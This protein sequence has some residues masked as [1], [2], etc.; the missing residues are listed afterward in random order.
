MPASSAPSSPGVVM[1]ETKILEGILQKLMY[2]DTFGSPKVYE[3]GDDIQTHL[4]K[5]DDYIN[6][7]GIQGDE[8]KIAVLCN[9]ICDEARWELCGLLEFD[10]NKNDYSWIKSR[11]KKLF[12][13]KATKITPL[14]KLFQC[15]QKT[16]QRTREFLSEI[17]RQGYLLMKG[18]DSTEREAHMTKAFINGLGNKNVK[19]ALAQMTVTTLDEAYELV[20]KEYT[21][22]SNDTE[23]DDVAR[24]R[25]VQPSVSEM[26]K[27]QNQMSIIQKQLSFIVRILQSKE[28][29]TNKQSYAD[30]VRRRVDY[31][32]KKHVAV[33]Q[34]RPKRNYNDVTFD[35]PQKS[36]ECWTCGNSGHIARFCPSRPQCKRCG[37][38]GHQ[39]TNCFSTTR[40]VSAGRVRG[41]R[42]LRGEY[43]EQ[44]WEA[45]SSNDSMPDSNS[46]NETI[47][48]DVT[49]HAI[50]HAISVHRPNDSESEI[51][52]EKEAEICAMTLHEGKS[53]K[54]RPKK[55]AVPSKRA[56]REYPPDVVA[57]AEF[58]DGKRRRPSCDKTLI[59]ESNQEKAANKPIIK[60]MCQ[61]KEAKIFCDTGA[62]V[63]VADFQFVQQ[64]REKDP[65]I[66]LRKTSKVIRCANDSNMNVVG[67]VRLNITIGEFTRQCK[68]W[69]VSKLFPRII[70]GIRTLK[71]MGICVDPP[72]DCIRLQSEAI[73]F[74]SKVRPETVHSS[75][76]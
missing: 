28:T 13:S 53:M 47:D 14:I 7:C 44:N 34:T 48:D 73:P 58:I 57:W 20:K 69:V 1:A 49:R 62:E 61:G 2:K 75:G 76:N 59:S 39:A 8:S 38:Y 31:I 60:G 71:D 72:N 43:S 19:K 50:V 10:D 30:A 23:T 54:V 35:R 9:S 36:M 65:S 51:P 27:L 3:P 6:A 74:V 17:R 4:E 11:L 52:I 29:T 42:D 55:R 40:V 37:R 5:V 21:I 24:V 45:I 33:S 68:V 41:L 18:L 64:L 63:N 26:E 32:P 12:E 25:N 46:E 15:K 16:N 70:L 56:K 67:W 22:C 66:K